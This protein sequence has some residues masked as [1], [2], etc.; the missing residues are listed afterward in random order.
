MQYKYQLC[1]DGTV[2]AYRLPYLLAGDA[3]LLKQESK[4]YEFFYNN[5]VPGKHY[6]S[7]KRDLSDLVE[8]IMWAKEHDQKVLQIAKSARQFARDN[9]LPDNILCYHVV[10][11]HVRNSCKNYADSTSFI[12]YLNIYHRITCFFY[13]LGME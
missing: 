8:K 7:V 6:I 9:L 5:L 13:T 1:I 11:F 3:L 2:A 10:L 12:F 4:Y